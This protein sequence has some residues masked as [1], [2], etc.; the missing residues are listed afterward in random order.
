[1]TSEKI[2]DRSLA[3]KLRTAQLERGRYRTWTRGA[4]A[5]QLIVRESDREIHAV[6]QRPGVDPDIAHVGIA[7]RRLRAVKRLANLL[8]RTRDGQRII[9]RRVHG[10]DRRDDVLEGRL[11]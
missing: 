10:P 6:H 1:M 7:G 9:D 8:Q 5:G 11:H 4:D 2:A 3:L